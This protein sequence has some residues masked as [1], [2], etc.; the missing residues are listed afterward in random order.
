MK[1]RILTN[2]RFCGA[3]RYK[4]DVANEGDLAPVD[5]G[6]KVSQKNVNIFLVKSRLQR[7]FWSSHTA[8]L[9]KW[10]VKKRLTR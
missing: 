9:M 2:V 7:L 6:K 5:Q 3:S 8:L 1:L 4:S 10:H